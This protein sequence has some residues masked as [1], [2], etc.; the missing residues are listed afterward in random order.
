MPMPGGVGTGCYSRHDAG[1]VEELSRQ[2]S[3]VAV[4]E[5]EEGLDD[6]DMGGEAGGEGCNDPVDDADEDTAQGH[7]EEADEA[8]EDVD[9]GHLFDVS[10]LLKEVVEHLEGQ[11]EDGDGGSFQ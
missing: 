3:H 2:V 7:H 4:E 5:D 11:G 8:Q 6:T 1:E 9:D 10:K